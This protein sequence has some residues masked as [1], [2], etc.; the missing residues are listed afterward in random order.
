MPTNDLA[1]RGPLKEH[2][3]LAPSTPARVPEASRSRG[4]H[5]L[6]SFAL[7]G[8]VFL[9]SLAG[10]VSATESL[11]FVR[12]GSGERSSVNLNGRRET[13][14]RSLAEQWTSYLEQLEASQGVEPQVA[15][16]VQSFWKQL[17]EDLRRSPRPPVAGPTEQDTFI[18]VW[19]QGKHHFEV[20]FLGGGEVEWFYRDRETESFLGAEGELKSAVE[21]AIDYFRRVSI[22]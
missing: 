21:A 16:T 5:Q 12:T 17:R 4:G 7:A 3:F 18:L 9:A 22:S 10:S 14:S 19:D 15:A 1:F 11:S 6:A 20:E 8:G 13:A 2:E